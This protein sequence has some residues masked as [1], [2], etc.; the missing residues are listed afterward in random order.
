MVSYHDETTAY[1]YDIETG[2]RLNPW[3]RFGNEVTNDSID[4]QIKRI[5][6]EKFTIF[7]QDRIFPLLLL[8]LAIFLAYK[9]RSKTDQD[10][11]LPKK[12][13]WLVS[14]PALIVIVGSIVVMFGW[15]A[16]IDVLKSL[17]PGLV[18]MKFTTALS[19]FFSGLIAYSIYRS[20]S[21]QDFT[22]QVVLPVAT[23]VV[24]V[25][26]AT[27]LVSTFLGSALELKTCLLQKRLGLFRQLLQED[28]R[29]VRC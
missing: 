5:N 25:L 29:L 19:F 16:N 12:S 28:L 27:L 6:A 7:L 8:I 4:A 13:K 3:N 9:K 2:E 20:H 26:M 15:F 14:L 1:Y 21:Y 11:R 22:S 10:S 18:T 23:L 24:M 17:V